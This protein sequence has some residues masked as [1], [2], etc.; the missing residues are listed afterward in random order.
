LKFLNDTTT[1]VKIFYNKNK[2]YQPL[3]SFFAGF[4]WD[5]ITLRRID[6]LLDNII[7]FSYLIL[8]GVFIFLL[9]MTYEDRLQKQIFVRFK[10]W[11]PNLVQFFFGGLFSGYFVYYFQ[12]ASLSKNGLFLLFLVFL[13]ISNEFIKNRLSNLIFQFVYYYLAALSFFIFYLPVLFK[14]MNVFVFIL[15]G[16]IS[17]LFVAGLIYLLFM[18]MGE[19]IKERLRNLII[20]L[21]T[22]YI[23]FNLLYFTNLIPPVPL[24]LKE[25]G[26]YHHVS[27]VNGTYKLKFEKGNWYNFF[28]DSDDEF[29]RSTGDTVFCYASVFA[30][31]DLNTS[32]Y[33]HW[34]MYNDAQ[35]KWISTDR[36]NYAIA[37]GRDGGYRGYTFKK[38]VSPGLWR[39][40]VETEREQLL[41]R[42]SF[43]IINSGDEFELKEIYK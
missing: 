34:Q 30:P 29:H 11:Y 17:S 2:K 41:G 42:I 36:S 1:S 27:R 25:A 43:E 13:L 37:G 16:I 8:A 18:Q 26:V 33:H 24:S 38:N 23:I 3:I 39:I 21:S 12:S 9:N 5:S 7:M 14:T 40:D 4:I 19:K 20:I 32:I 10:D 31:T 22:I 28:K 15:S 35:D 6:L